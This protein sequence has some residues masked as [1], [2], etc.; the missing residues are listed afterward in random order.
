MIKVYLSFTCMCEYSVAYLSILFASNQS[1]V[2]VIKCLSSNCFI[3]QLQF[4]LGITEMSWCLSLHE[5]HRCYLSPKRSSKENLLIMGLVMEAK[6]IKITIKMPTAIKQAVKFMMSG[7]VIPLPLRENSFFHCHL[8]RVSW[9]YPSSDREL[10]SETVYIFFFFLRGEGQGRR[11]CREGRKNSLPKQETLQF[12]I[13]SSSDGGILQRSA[14]K[15]SC[16]HYR[17]L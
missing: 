10:T 15:F 13:A 8:I 3:C 7:L 14:Q 9:F 11:G 6:I 12:F 5:T 2:C 4:C 16:G 1:K 17:G